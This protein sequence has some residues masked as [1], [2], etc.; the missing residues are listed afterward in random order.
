[1]DYSVVITTY[2]GEKFILQQLRSI[3]DQSHLPAEVIIADDHSNDHT[4]ELIEE[5]IYVNKLASWKLF[6]NSYTIGWKKNF[7]AAIEKASHDTIFLSDQDDIWHSHKA[8][9]LIEYFQSNPT[10]N[11]LS[12]NF[13]KIDEYGK[14]I[15]KSSE[16]SQHLIYPTFSYKNFRVQRPGC[17]YAF[18]KNFFDK[19]K[20]FWIEEMPH[21]ALLWWYS[22]LTNSLAVCPE[23]LISY[24][25]HSSNVS[26]NRLTRSEIIKKME[27]SLLFLKNLDTNL[28][29]IDNNVSYEKQIISDLINYTTL[30]IKAYNTYDFY[31]V[32]KAL[33]LYRR[34]YAS[35]ATPTNHPL[36]SE[37]K[38]F[39]L[40][41]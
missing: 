22:A 2:N 25:R 18:R 20:N 38:N 27:E 9:T 33:T 8:H 28:S 31:S 12:S 40:T 1:M 4:C 13:D 36:L 24:R 39:L 30:R 21:D 26:G 10:I 16:S 14:I 7:M 5:F 23:A 34:C 35:Y 19:I 6:V 3:M 37:V 41:K 17:T 15:K 11:V 32:C 29:A